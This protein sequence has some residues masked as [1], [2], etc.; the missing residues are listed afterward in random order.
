M[1]TEGNTRADRDAEDTGGL[2]PFQ[3][4]RRELFPSEGEVRKRFE[5]WL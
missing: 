4:S 5:R 2:L 3:P 1:L